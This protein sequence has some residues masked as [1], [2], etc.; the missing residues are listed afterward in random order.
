MGGRR[1]T[2][3]PLR[4]FHFW[5]AGACPFPSQRRF[6]LLGGEGDPDHSCTG[7]CHAFSVE[8][9]LA[10]TLRP[11]DLVILDK[12]PAHKGTAIQG[13]VEA[14]GARLQFLPP[15]IV[16]TSTYAIAQLEALLRKAAT[17]TVE[18]LWTAVGD[19]P[20]AFTPSWSANYFAAPRG[21]LPRDRRR[22]GRQ[23]GLQ[24]LPRGGGR[25]G[26]GRTGT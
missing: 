24:N 21:D 20:D 22:F 4:T 7:V 17:R 9:V 25:P 2:A 6:V 14:R 18:G 5:A 15:S 13:A 8:Q 1:R 10:P 3:G 19:L 11:G 12:L 23:L 16:R 26:G